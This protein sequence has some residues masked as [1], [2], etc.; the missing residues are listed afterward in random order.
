VSLI[1]PIVQLV[2]THSRARIEQWTEQDRVREKAQQW[3]EA[4]N[5]QRNAEIQT[6]G[7]ASGNQE[8]LE[9]AGA[10]SHEMEPEISDLAGIQITMMLEQ[11]LRLVR[12][13]EKEYAVPWK[14]R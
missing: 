4:A 5:A 8:I 9:P 11:F 10:S 12:D 1:T 3:V 13:S 14:V 2:T 6:Q 7:T